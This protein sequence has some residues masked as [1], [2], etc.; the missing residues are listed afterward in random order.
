MGS[1]LPAVA[2]PDGG[3]RELA[4]PP[5]PRDRWSY[6]V[7]G[8]LT[9]LLSVAFLHLWNVDLA[10][11][12]G[13]H[14]DGNFWAATAKNFVESHHYYVNPR[15]GAPGQQ[16]LYDF[17]LPHS[18]QLVGWWLLGLFT[19]DYGL[20]LNLYF[21]LT[22]ELAAWTA[23][24]ALRKL[25]ITTPVAIAGSV[26]FSFLPFHLL[27]GESHYFLSSLF[28]VPLVCLAAL[29]V[30][31]GEPLFWFQPGLP[32]PARRRRVTTAG[33]ISILTAILVAGD[34]PYNCFFACFLIL[35]AGLLGRYRNGHRRALATAA[36]LLSLQVTAFAVNLAP[37]F[38]YMARYGRNHQVASRRPHEAEVFGMKIAQLLLPVTNH[39]LYLFNDIKIRYNGGD[40]F[41][42][43]APNENDTTSLG[44]VG[45]AGFILLTG[46]IF[47]GR[48]SSKIA[49]SL[50]AL[51][52]LNLGAVLLGTIGGLGALFATLVSAQWRA[53]DR[54]SVFI[55]FFC[56][57]AIALVADRYVCPRLQSAQW[58]VYAGAVLIAVLGVLDQTPADIASR[59][60]I[61]QAEYLA[62][63]RFFQQIESRVPPAGMIFQ[64]PYVPYPENPRVGYMF[65]YD[66]LRPYL[67]TGTLRWSYGAM[68]GRPGAEWEAA[69]AKQSAREMV[70]ALRTAGFS[71]IYLDRFGY[72]GSRDRVESGLAGVLQ[73]APLVSADHRFVFFALPR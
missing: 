66:H 72:V 21:L 27:R 73:A 20:V 62:D 23:L 8:L 59:A 18:T 60:R 65:D 26:L 70:A 55:G 56:I 10:I 57:A 44:A 69:T 30:A 38:L 45:A 34:D 19:R 5:P 25:G 48:G 28:V 49:L 6:A 33:A 31:T 53:Y 71:G 67:H 13:G 11:P 52:Q 2:P 1:A 29:W 47:F 15:L 16:A 41:S 24:F 36:L 14:G 43:S 50:D 40:V 35:L 63:G 4:P 68:K 32:L 61:A 51:S 12:F 9:L 58:R 54:I 39:R 37:N 46:W 42:D 3:S 22:F 17:P 64:L 7:S